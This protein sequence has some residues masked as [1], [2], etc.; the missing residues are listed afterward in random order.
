MPRIGYQH[1]FVMHGLLSL[2]AAHKA[3]LLPNDRRMYL[4][5]ADYHQTVGSEVFRPLLKD[6]RPEMWKSIFCFASVVTL[7][8]F[9]R[10]VRSEFFHLGDPVLSLLEVIGVL[11]GVKTTLAPMLNS[12]LRS[13]LAPMVYG[14]F[15]GEESG[16][17]ERT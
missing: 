3:Y 17:N 13:E 8:T 1:P 10:P 12:V 4:A 14:V 9:S 6:L 2:A 5:L 16:S 15:P 7:F 11:R